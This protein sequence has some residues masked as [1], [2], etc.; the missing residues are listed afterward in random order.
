MRL[1]VLSLPFMPCL[2]LAGLRYLPVMLIIL[3]YS[4]TVRMK[5]ACDIILVLRGA[6]L[7][8]CLPRTLA[9]EHAR[10]RVSWALREGNYRK[11][12]TAVGESER[13]TYDKVLSH[14][15]DG[16]GKIHSCEIQIENAFRVPRSTCTN[17]EHKSHNI[18]IHVRS[19]KCAHI[20]NTRRLTFLL[21]DPGQCTLS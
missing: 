17:P 7:I 18:T 4:S 1:P 3:A 16:D 21:G 13:H 8:A 6:G 15:W 10:S 2:Y 12:A 9:N 14:A 5:E 20:K 19:T 11:Y